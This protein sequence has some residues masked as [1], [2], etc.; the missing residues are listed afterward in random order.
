MIPFAEPLPHW[1]FLLHYEK[2]YISK[3]FENMVDF[4]KF[5]LSI[6]LSVLKYKSFSGEHT[7]TATT[8]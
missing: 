1:S 3:R 2:K 5:G 6:G 7:V 8:N 4:V